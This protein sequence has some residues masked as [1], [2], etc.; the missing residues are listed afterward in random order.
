MFYDKKHQYQVRGSCITTHLD[1]GIQK[2][3]IVMIRSVSKSLVAFIAVFIF[4]LSSPAAF[5]SAEES[6]CASCHTS[7]RAL[8]KTIRDIEASKPEVEET[9]ESE[10][11]G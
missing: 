9:T 10:G 7:I 6:S 3:S 8:L 5:V 2:W 4:L 11:E 1:G